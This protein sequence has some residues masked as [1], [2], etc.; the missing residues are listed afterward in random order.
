MDFNY[1]VNRII[2]SCFVFHNIIIY[3]FT[4]IAEEEIMVFRSLNET[5]FDFSQVDISRI[6]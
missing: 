1:C 4:L 2:S 5:Y 3:S 6:Y